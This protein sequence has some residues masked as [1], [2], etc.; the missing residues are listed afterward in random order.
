MGDAWVTL[1]LGTRCIPYLSFLLKLHYHVST[2]CNLRL[3]LA[4]NL[5]FN[6]SIQTQN[7]L[8]FKLGLG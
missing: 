1:L 5:D 4:F 7:K 2:Y 8:R 6:L 3:Y